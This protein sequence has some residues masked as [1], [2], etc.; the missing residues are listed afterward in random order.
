LSWHFRT[1]TE[2]GYKYWPTWTD[3]ALEDIDQIVIVFKNYYAPFVDT[4]DKKYLPS[5]RDPK[6]KANRAPSP[7]LAKIYKFATGL[8]AHGPDLGKL[9][10]A[11]KKLGGFGKAQAAPPAADFKKESAEVETTRKLLPEASRDL[12]AIVA[13]GDAQ[14]TQTLTDLTTASDTFRGAEIS[15]AVHP[16]RERAMAANIKAAAAPLLVQIGNSH[17]LN[18]A[19]LVG[20]SAVA[21]DQATKLSDITKR[22]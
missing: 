22:P 12:I 19:A 11:L 1:F 14:Q 7:R 5:L 15:A 13:E 20:A 2:G 17:I 18:V 9:I 3:Y 16:I 8:R 4:Y 6:K 10:A 21:V